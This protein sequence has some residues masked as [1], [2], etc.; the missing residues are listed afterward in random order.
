VVLD[1]HERSWFIVNSKLV[2]YDGGQ[3]VRDEDE[4]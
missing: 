4:Y 3:N 1:R 2:G